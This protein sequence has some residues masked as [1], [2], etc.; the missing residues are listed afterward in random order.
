MQEYEYAARAVHHVEVE[1][2]RQPLPKLERHLVEVRVGIEQIV[3][4]HDRGVA[5]GVAAAEVA[6]LEHGDVGETVLLRKVVGRGEPVSAAADD[7]GV[8]TR[9]R[10]RTAPRERPALVVRERVSRQRE[11]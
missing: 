11:D 7:D 2:A 5:P 9:L 1:L 4:A 6:L 8:V 3:R 10:M